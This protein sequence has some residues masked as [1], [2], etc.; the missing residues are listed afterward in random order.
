MGTAPYD[1]TT[2]NINNLQLAIVKFTQAFH[3]KVAMKFSDEIVDVSTS[4]HLGNAE[5]M[6][7]NTEGNEHKAES[8][9]MESPLVTFK[10]RVDR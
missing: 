2:L 6:S 7:S 3:F 4:C 9:S 5:S 10:S 1:G 8:Y